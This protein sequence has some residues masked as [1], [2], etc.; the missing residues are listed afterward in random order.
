MLATVEN[1]TATTHCRLFLCL[2]CLLHLSLQH[3]QFPGQLL[4][5]GPQHTHPMTGGSGAWGHITL[6]KLARVGVALPLSLL[7]FP[8]L[9]ELA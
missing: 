9:L 3:S 6:D 1:R 2:L 7:S 5:E 4:A 8:Q